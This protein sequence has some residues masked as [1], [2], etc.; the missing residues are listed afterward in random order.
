MTAL[1]L[2]LVAAS[3]GYAVRGIRRQARKRRML[4]RLEAERRVRAAQS[5][6]YFRARYGVASPEEAAELQRIREAGL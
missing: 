2:V 4:A 6:A 5:A 3:F 1:A